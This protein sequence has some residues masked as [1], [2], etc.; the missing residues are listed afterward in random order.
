MKRLVH[1]AVTREVLARHHFQFRKSLGQ[2][3]LI[4]GNIL[5]KIVAAAELDK[6]CGVLEVGPGIGTLTQMLAEQAGW[7]VAVEKDERLLP[8]LQ[9]TLAGQDHVQIVHGDVLQLD[10]SALFTRYFGGRR[11]C[12]VANLPYYITTPIIM[13][14]LE[15]HL[16]LERIVVM[17]QQEVAERM[18]ARPGGKEYG[19]L[20]L[21]VQYYT[22][23]RVVCRVPRTVF[24]PQPQVDS[25]VMCLKVRQQPAVAVKDPAFFFR[26][27]KAAFAQRRKTLLNNLLHNLP[28]PCSRE[29]L[30]AVLKQMGIAPER[31]GETLSLEEFARLAD[32]LQKM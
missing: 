16:P 18:T 17:V 9:E 31:R 8:I 4:D 11:T 12:V 24:I 1:P 20:S 14:L 7:V 19:A 29:Q 2:N 3:F 26:V 22:E 21:A 13:K 27:V 25:L 30:Q 15:E 5:E 23:T 28:L 32:S 10:L 6:D